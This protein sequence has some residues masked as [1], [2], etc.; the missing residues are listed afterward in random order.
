[1]AIDYVKLAATALRLIAAAGREITVIKF[2]QTPADAGK[3]WE[4][5]SDPQT[6]PDATSTVKGVFVSPAGAP[7]LGLQ[8]ISEDLLKITVEIAIVHA[9]SFDLAEAD[10]IIDGG[11]HKTISFVDKL[12]PADT[13]LLYFIGVAR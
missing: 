11:V 3:P 5:P 6:V 12:K 2:N 4:G 7:A 10:E 13:T 1:M 9:G 8:A